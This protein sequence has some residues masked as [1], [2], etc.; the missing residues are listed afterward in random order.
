[1]RLISWPLFLRCLRRTGAVFPPET[2]ARWQAVLAD[3]EALLRGEKLFPCWRSGTLGGVNLR[4]V[5]LDP[6]LVDVPGWTEGWAAAAYLDEETLVSTES[7]NRFASMLSGN[8]MLFAIW[9]H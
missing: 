6:R 9:L 3:A 2:G 1:M 8:A 7:W 5:F 4:M